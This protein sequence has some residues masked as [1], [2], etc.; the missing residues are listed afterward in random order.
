MVENVVGLISGV[1][2]WALM[3]KPF[4]LTYQLGKNLSYIKCNDD[5]D[6]NCYQPGDETITTFI[7]KRDDV[8]FSSY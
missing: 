5:C 3:S 2:E 7:N 6:K 8:S 1:E 4:F